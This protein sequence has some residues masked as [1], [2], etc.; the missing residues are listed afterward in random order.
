M[1]SDENAPNINYN[2]FNLYEE[3]LGVWKGYVK[4]V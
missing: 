2:S 4:Y 1:S 3:N